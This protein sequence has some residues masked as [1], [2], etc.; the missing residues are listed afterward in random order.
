V[1]DVRAAIEFAAFYDGVDALSILNLIERVC[2]Q[3]DEVGE[4]AG[5]D[6]AKV[7]GAM[8]GDCRVESGGLQGFQR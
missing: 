6:Y 1:V 2:V 4:L 5:L 8:E 7:V 3:E